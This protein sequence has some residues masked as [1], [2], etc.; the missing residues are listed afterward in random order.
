[1]CVTNRHS[2]TSRGSMSALQYTVTAYLP[3]KN[4]VVTVNKPVLGHSTQQD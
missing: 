2:A 3:N 1:M 4:Y